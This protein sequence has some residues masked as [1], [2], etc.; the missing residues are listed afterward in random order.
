MMGSLD[1]KRAAQP[2]SFVVLPG[3]G[4]RKIRRAAPLTAKPVKRRHCPLLLFVR[5]RR[6]S[7]SVHPHA[8]LGFRP[9]RTL[10][11]TQVVI[12]LKT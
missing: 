1:E 6:A 11:D 2:L 10:R 7:G 8:A 12:G 9:S 4:H 3:T 5:V